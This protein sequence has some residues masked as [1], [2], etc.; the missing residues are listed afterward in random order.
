MSLFAVCQEIAWSP[1]WPVIDL[2]IQVSLSESY[3]VQSDRAQVINHWVY[4]D[5]FDA[6]LIKV[7]LK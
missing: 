5:R 7:N 1:P 4:S 3:S 6:N 2:A